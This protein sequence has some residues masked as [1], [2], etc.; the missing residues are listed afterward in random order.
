MSPLY[1]SFVD[2]YKLLSGNTTSTNTFAFTIR[3]GAMTRDSIP[4]L[5]SSTQSRYQARSSLRWVYPLTNIVRVSASVQPLH[6]SLRPL[7]THT[8]ELSRFQSA[9]RSPRADPQQH[10]NTAMSS[11]R[12]PV[13]LL[14]LTL[15]DYPLSFL[16]LAVVQIMFGTL[17]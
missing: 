8:L 15:N 10:R 17:I 1:V 14:I 12:S 2:L 16:L 5:T 13:F 7:I 3:I 11:P 4:S 6:Q 9:L